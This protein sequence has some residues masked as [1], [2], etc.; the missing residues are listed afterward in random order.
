M[1]APDVLSEAWD[2]FIE[3]RGIDGQCKR[4]IAISEGEFRALKL[5][6]NTTRLV[7]QRRAAS[8]IAE[9]DARGLTLSE[10][11]ACLNCGRK[12]ADHKNGSCDGR[13]ICPL[14]NGTGRR[15]RAAYACALCKGTGCLS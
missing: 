8:V 10:T 15:I 6:Q 3:I 14:C 9:L 7:V 12:L 11:T 2:H 1:S 4:R 13:K 5:G